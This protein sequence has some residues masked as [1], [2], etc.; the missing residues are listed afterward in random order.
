M[1]DAEQSGPGLWW[2]VAGGLTLLVLAVAFVFAFRAE[3]R[4][5]AARRGRVVRPGR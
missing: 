1:A 3:A 2:G 5:D 4:A